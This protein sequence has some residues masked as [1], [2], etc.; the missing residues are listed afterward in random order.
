MR[1]RISHPIVIVLVLV[2]AGVVLAGNV[3]TAGPSSSTAGT[4]TMVAQLSTTPGTSG[5]STSG[6]LGTSTP[7]GSTL[8]APSTPANTPSATSGAAPATSESASGTSNVQTVEQIVSVT[9][10]VDAG[11]TAVTAFT[12]PAGRLLVLTDI[13]I[14]NPGFVSACGASIAPNGAPSTTTTESGTGALCVPSQ[15]SLNLGLT[16]GM[17][18]AGGQSVVL[19]NTTTGTALHFHLR[20][21]LTTT[22][23]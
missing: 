3:L 4:A 20:G 1:R 18:F 23:T 21:F 2:A 11:A 15:T 19:G 12:V 7:V 8:T 6:G 13:V 5:S 22:A 14:T 9:R 10:V 16:T 17:E